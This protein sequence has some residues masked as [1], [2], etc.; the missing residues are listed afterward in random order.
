MPDFV[1]VRTGVYFDSVSLMQVSQTVKRTPG[2]SDALIGMGTPLNL[3]L[4]VSTGFAVPDE[5]GPNDLVV[6]LRGEDDAA[7][8]A[9][10]SG[11]D[12]ALAELRSAASRSADLTGDSPAL[13]IGSAAQRTDANLAVI[14][15]PGEYAAVDSLDAIR[16]NCSVMLFSD[17][18]D[19]AAEV[20]LKDAAA[21]ADV[22]VMGPDCGTAVVSGAALGFANR[23]RAGRFGVVA[24]SGTGAQQVMCLLEAAGEGVSHVLGT[25][26]RDLSAEVGG[27]SAAQALRALAADESTERVIVVSKPADPGVLAELERL[28]ADLGVPVTWAALGPGL[29]DLTCAV[30]QALRLADAPVP[31]W[32]SKLAE[33][34]APAAGPL[35]G[36]FCGGTLA[37]E[38][39][40]I[41]A[42]ALG[43]IPSNI[44]LA[45][46]PRISGQETVDGHAVLDFGAD[47]MTQGRAHPMIDPSLRLERIRAESR[48]AG[49]LLLDLVLG[50]G[51]HPDPAPEL[52]AAIR[53]AR[54]QAAAAGREL[55]VVVSVIGA[56]GDPQG[57]EHTV[58]ALH[59][60]GAS[61]FSS[62]ARAVRHA[63]ELLAHRAPA[64]IP[65]AGAAGASAGSVGSPPGASEGAPGGSAT[66]TPLETFVTPRPEPTGAAPLRGLL[67]D[68]PVVVSAGVSLFAEALAEQAVAVTEVPWQPPA[69]DVEALVRVLADPRREQA[70]AIALERMLAAGADLVA[71]RPAS[72]CLGLRPG[73]FLHAGPPLEWARASGPMRGALAGAAVFEGLADSLPEAE[74]K[75]AAG[76]FTFEPCH[77][78]DAVGP[79]AGVVSP[80]MWMFELRDPAHD[81]TAYCSLNEGLGKVLRYGANNDEVLTR[82][83]WMRDV[84]GPVLAEAVAAHGPIDIRAYISQMVQMGDEGHNRNRSATLMF[85]RDVVPHI[86]RSGRDPDDI[87]EVCRFIGAND[88]F[89]L[90]LVMPA[91]K[92]ATLAARGVPGSTLVTTMARN[93][94]DFGIQ[95][96]G[97]GDT[98]YTGPAQVAEGLFLGSF[99]PD[100]ANPDIG[101]S[102]ITETAGVG[103]FAM[104]TAPAIVRL[105]GGGV[106]FALRTTRRMYEIT[107]GEHPAH[108]I[109]ILE[110]RGVPTGIDVTKVLRT[111]VLPQIN[112]GMAGRV[113][114]VGQVG[115]GLVNPPEE[116]FTEAIRS[117]ADAV[118]APS[119]R[120]SEAPSAAE[121]VG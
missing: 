37:D 19:V 16:A 101:D 71:L 95:V 106:P 60:A 81:T 93:G 90:N 100:D 21:A 114:G 6:A 70:N 3:E 20:A 105:V 43:P 44:P 61:V 102:A 15:V 36:L 34:G 76:D 83:R 17:N 112:T 79:M 64:D 23:V 120:T 74:E 33:A 39:M 1:D 53:D 4:M 42:E 12:A 52:A 62:N 84:L 108:Q 14:S 25:G 10:R 82:L 66:A 5:A 54:A 118:E 57:M 28:A 9:G 104:A 50:Y 8:D 63:L 98:W 85:L 55:P 59:R 94:T 45:G 117:L 51:S 107:L 69:G 29:P 96:S 86:A 47:E 103:G 113:A 89:A 121:P 97:T 22:L 11:L 7:L 56:A 68:E 30:E 67:A 99:G 58:S 92:L 41:A 109:P 27:R 18:V 77:S 87:A 48:T 111:G 110:F 80:S 72:E 31:E 2:I 49:V 35:R 26:G 73:E 13:T 40:V 116:C 119:F 65:Q 88:H 115:A 38:A 91:C 46:A 32:P 78:R 75:L 24:A